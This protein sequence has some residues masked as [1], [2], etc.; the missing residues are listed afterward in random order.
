MSGPAEKVASELPVAEE[1]TCGIG[2]AQHAAIPERMAVMFE[3]L[4]KTL[5]LH[6]TM[7][8]ADDPNTRKE[9]EVY[10]DLSASWVRIAELVKSAAAM[11]A[12]QRELPMGPHDESKWGEA[13]VRAFEKFVTGQSQLLALLR[14]AA[15]RDEQ[16]LASMTMP[17]KPA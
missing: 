15:E 11:M 12:T 17:K 7:L 5:S 4:A 13:H 1:P 9:D 8:V 14:V 3:G 16:M 6:R 2:I 10:A